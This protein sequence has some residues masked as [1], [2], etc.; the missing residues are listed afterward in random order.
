MTYRDIVKALS[1]KE[2]VSQKQIEREMKKAIR[3]AGLNCSP[4]ALIEKVAMLATR[5]DYIS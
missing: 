4:Q 1:K 5:E 2:Q 3:N